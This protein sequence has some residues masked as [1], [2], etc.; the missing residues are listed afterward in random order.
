MEDRHKAARKSDLER[1]TGLFRGIA[2]LI[3]KTLRTRFTELSGSQS[4]GTRKSLF[5]IN[6]YI[7]C[8]FL[9]VAA[10]TQRLN[11]V[12]GT[13]SCKALQQP[14]TVSPSPTI[15]LVEIKDFHFLLSIFF[16]F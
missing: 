3:L 7:L 16:N 11:A 1:R 6:I 13:A 12:Y 2:T 9:L 4:Q 5:Y 10:V 15:G 8:R 14:E